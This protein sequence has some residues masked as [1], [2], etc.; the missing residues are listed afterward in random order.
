M[1]PLF[2]PLCLN[3]S[4][5]ITKSHHCPYLIIA[6]Y[7]EKFKVK[8]VCHAANLGRLSTYD[9]TNTLRGKGLASGHVENK[10]NEFI[11]SLNC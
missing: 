5:K 8:Q 7:V 10:I 9:W 6:M 11:P 3:Q 1:A 2:L 4:I